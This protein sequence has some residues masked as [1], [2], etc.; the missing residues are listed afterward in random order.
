MKRL[1]LLRGVIRSGMS[2]S[3]IPRFSDSGSANEI[4]RLTTGA[5]AP[6][7]DQRPGFGVSLSIK[8]ADHALNIAKKSG[9]ELPGVVLARDNMAAARDYGGECLDSSAM[10]GIL[11]QKAGLAFWNEKSRQGGK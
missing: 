2:C 5:Y 6:P 9:V 10:Y 3:I 4:Y 7:L 1:A 11:R 8:D